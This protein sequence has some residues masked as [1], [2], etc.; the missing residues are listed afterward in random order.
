MSTNWRS[1][2]P[3]AI[4]EH[5]LMAAEITWYRRHKSSNAKSNDSGQ[6]TPVKEDD[7]M[8][9]DGSNDAEGGEGEMAE[10]EE[11]EGGARE[12]EKEGNTT[13]R[14]GVSPPPLLRPLAKRYTAI[15]DGFQDM[16]IGWNLKTTSV[17]EIVA[18]RSEWWEMLVRDMREYE[19]TA[20][21]RLKKHR[22]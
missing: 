8:T 12:G 11:E 10:E 2:K 5:T 7:K 18:K 6:K 22:E 1:S 9:V 21:D 3:E 14:E 19:E 13:M 17:K 15:D 20:T 4:L 16:M